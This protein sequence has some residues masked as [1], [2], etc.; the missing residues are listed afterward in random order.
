M[1]C[2]SGHVNVQAARITDFTG[3]GVRC[4]ST[5]VQAADLNRLKMRRGKRETVCVLEVYVN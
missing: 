3:R 2:V 1:S 5:L 4:V